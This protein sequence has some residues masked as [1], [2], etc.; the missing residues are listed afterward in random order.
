[1]K[2]FFQ[3]H[4]R[5]IFYSSWLL[6]TFIQA[7]FTQLSNDEA[8]YWVYSHYLAWGY[9]DHPPMIALMVKAGYFLFHNELGVRLFA[10]VFSTLTLL[11]IE[12]LLDNKNPF[13]F[14]IIALSLAAYQLQA[15]VAVPDSP[16]LL[17]TALFFLM[18]RDYTMKPSWSNVVK[19]AVMA[20][21]LLYSKYHGVLVIFFT[22]LS[23]LQLFKNYK[24]W[25]IGLLIVAGL[26]PHLYWQYA[27]NWPSLHYHLL[28]RNSPA[29]QFNFTTE[30]ILGQL[31]LP[32]PFAGFILLPAAF[33]YKTRNKMERALF[34]VLVGFYVFF[35]ISSLRGRV[36]A[37]WTAPVLI[38]LVVLS[39]QYINGRAKWRKIL[40]WQLPVTLMLVL[41]ARVVMIFDIVPIAFVKN[42]FHSWK[43]WQNEMKQR[44]KGMPVAFISSYQD[45]SMYWFTTGQFTYYP[46]NYR[47]RKT[48]Y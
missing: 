41:A 40:I 34:A 36:E 35:L 13:L 3:K 18:Y 15:F 2:I 17:F 4:H 21:L 12:K 48:N 7:A 39:H 10:S 37:N 16:L 24:T 14:Y 38:P 22:L 6:L 46:P 43:G 32:G 19:L 33:L 26:S 5:I 28:D 1:M 11:I 45:A 20:T 8:Y 44:T 9:F 31:F 47:V 30:Y 27:H 29:Y 42:K 23:N 25:I